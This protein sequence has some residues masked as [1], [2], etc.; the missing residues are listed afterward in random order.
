MKSL[1]GIAA[2]CAAAAFA[3]APA[4]AQDASPPAASPSASSPAEPAWTNGEVRTIDRATGRLTLRHE[5]IENLGMSGM[6][7]V[8]RAA[9]P[10]FLDSLKE[11]DRV[12]FVADR[13]DGVLTVMRIE[14][15]P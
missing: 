7:M 9:D 6:T 12:R 11:G 14:R 4:R 2:L 13:L 3:T 10:S 5:R 1:I 15:T 8:F